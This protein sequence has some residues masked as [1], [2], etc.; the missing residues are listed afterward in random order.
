[1]DFTFECAL[2][3]E[4]EFLWYVMTKNS[5]NDLPLIMGDIVCKTCS[6]ALPPATQDLLHWIN[7]HARQEYLNSL[8]T[9]P[10]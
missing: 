1:M 8:K 9:F 6:E 7:R 4:S 2:C 3:G 10:E 5:V